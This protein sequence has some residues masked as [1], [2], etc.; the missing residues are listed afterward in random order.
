MQCRHI[1]TYIHTCVFRQFR[2]KIGVFHKNQCY[3]RIFELF[4][5][6]LSQKRQFFAEN[7]LK[8]ITSVPGDQSIKTKLKTHE[9]RLCT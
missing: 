3:D 2:Q 6:V 1:P 4:S 7:I 8:I 9:H 5:F